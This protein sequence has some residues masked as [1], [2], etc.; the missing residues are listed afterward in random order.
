M[1]VGQARAVVPLTDGCWTVAGVG[2]STRPQAA[3]ETIPFACF[4][5]QMTQVK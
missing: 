3:P 4:R 2:S 1:Q 5:L